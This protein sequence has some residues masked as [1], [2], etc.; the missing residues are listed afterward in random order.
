MTFPCCPLSIRCCENQLDHGNLKVLSVNSCSQPLSLQ[1]PCLGTR[2]PLP[3]IACLPLPRYNFTMLGLSSSFLLLSYLLTH[4]CGSVGFI[5]ANCFNM[6]I[7]ITQSLCF[8]HRYYRKSPHKPLAGLFLS[9]VLLG[10]FALSGGITAVSEVRRP[11]AFTPHDFA[12]CPLSL[13]PGIPFLLCLTQLDK[14]LLPLTPS[15]KLLGQHLM[16]EM[17]DQWYPWEQSRP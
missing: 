2:Y 14:Y 1:Q 11:A 10:A 8:I 15:P 17:T 13:V 12:A 3:C 9:P 7:R 16:I 5:L 6:G 4:W